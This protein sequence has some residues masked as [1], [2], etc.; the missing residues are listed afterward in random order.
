MWGVSGHSKLAWRTVTGRDHG[1]HTATIVD[2]KSGRVIQ[3]YSVEQ[4]ADSIGVGQT[5]YSGD[6]S[7]HT[8]LDRGGGFEMED[9]TRG[10]HRVTTMNNTTSAESG[11]LTDADNNW[12]NGTESDRQTVAADAHYGAAETWDFYKTRRPQ[13]HRNNG[14][15]ANSRVHYGRL[16]QRVLERRLLLHDL[17]RRQRAFNPLVSLDV[18][19]HEMSHG[20]TSHTAGLYYF[21]E[22]G[23]LNEATSDIFGTMVE[24]FA[25]NAERPGRLLHRREDRA[26]FP[27]GYLRRMDTPYL[28]GVQLQLLDPAMGTRRPRTSPRAWATTSSTCWPRAPAARRSAACRTELDVQRH[29]GHRA[30]AGTR[31]PR[32][33]TAR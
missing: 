13:R 26:A 19:G 27:A 21:G 25:A 10:G 9:L 12:G 7:I 4:E 6:V 32:S 15:G 8:D 22:S 14:E 1:L 11:T 33:G 24:F 2:A 17:R 18:A 20:V 3:S 23:G 31:R 30:S 16:R 29:D 5:L 28:D